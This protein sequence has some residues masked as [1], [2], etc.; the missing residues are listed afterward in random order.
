M[1]NAVSFRAGCSYADSVV[2]Q[3]VVAFSTSDSRPLG[4]IWRITA[5]S[6][7]FYLEPTSPPRAFHLSVH[8][9]NSRFPAG[10]RFHLKVDGRAA[11]AADRRG[12][13]L[14]HDVPSE[15]YAFDGTELAPGVF[16]VARIRWNWDLQRPRYRSAAANTSRIPDITHNRTGA[17][18]SHQLPPNGAA[19]ID[20]VISYGEP[21]WPHPENSIRDNARLGPLYNNAGMCLTATS[22]RRSQTTDPA[23]V[24]LV[25]RLPERGEDP[26][27][28]MGAAPGPAA[29]ADMYWFVESITSRQVIDASRPS[30]PRTNT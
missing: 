1:E 12:D 27:R 10:H 23:P 3:I 11:A 14:V 6:T 9:P 30:D 13:F 8:G 21:Y 18:L 4:N 22:Y 29:P 5:K 19:D 20:L 25:P 17:R 24:G 7:D 28:I 15:G 2:E 16:R 26:N